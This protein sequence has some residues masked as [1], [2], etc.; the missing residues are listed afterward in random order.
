[1]A[2]CPS[3]RRSERTRLTRSPRRPA[4]ARRSPRARGSQPS[5]RGRY[6]FQ[7]PSSFIVAGS[8][9]PRMIVASISTATA[10]PTPICLMSSVLRQAK[11]ANTATITAAAA[12][13][14]LAVEAMPRRHGLLGGGTAI[15]ELL[16]PADD[17]HVVVHR[18]AEQD[19]EQEQRQPGDDA[20][21]RVEVQEALEVAVLEDPHEHAVG[22]AD[23]QQVEHDRGQR[24]HDRPER[25]QQEQ[26]RQPE[27][28]REHDRPVLLGGLPEI[29][30]TGG[31]AGHRVVHAGQP[32]RASPGS[33]A[34]AAC[35]APPS[36]PCSRRRPPAGSR[37]RSTVWLEFTLVSIGLNIWWLASA[38][39]SRLAI[40]G[41]PPARARRG[42]SP[43]P[44]PG[45]ERRGTASGSSR[46]SSRSACSA[47]GR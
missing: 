31:L 21:V 46:S 23:R 25:E 27:H 22:R 14:V 15:D 43:P 44:R 30:V 2:G 5:Q 42:A 18:E 4:R 20:S 10:R 13:T 16:D 6:Q 35:R 11:I 33:P 17:E 38:F 32:C 40:A 45:S 3:G 19:H 29:V 47:A 8:S 26:E 28:E 7:R 24:D 12:V 39:C 41:A 34:G 36:T 9:T 1:M 37:T